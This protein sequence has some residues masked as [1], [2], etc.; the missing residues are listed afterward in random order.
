MAS[1]FVCAQRHQS[2]KF[3][4]NNGKISAQPHTIVEQIFFPNGNVLFLSLFSLSKN[5]MRNIGWGCTEI[6]PIQLFELLRHET[7]KMI[8]RLK[9]AVYVSNF[10]SMPEFNL[11]DNLVSN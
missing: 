3:D 6:S 1:I 7:V 9:N 10:C 5:W 11:I 4:R 2:D 8:V